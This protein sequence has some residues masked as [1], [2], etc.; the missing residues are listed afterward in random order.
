[1]LERA[2]RKAQ[3]TGARTML[4]IGNAEH[5]LEPD[6][7]YDAII[8]HNVLWTLSRYEQ[9]FHEWRRILKPVG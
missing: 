3:E 7:G 1:M 4:V 6:A 2:H 9:A 8:A 5:T